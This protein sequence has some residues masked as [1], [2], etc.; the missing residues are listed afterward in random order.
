M[1]TN[2]CLINL[3]R[4]AHFPNESP[5]LQFRT[6]PRSPSPTSDT[7]DTGGKESFTQWVHGEFI[8][9]SE[10]I[11]PPNIHWVQGEYF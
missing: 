11:F 9:G 1:D 4:S 2:P 8:V 6:L 3:F 10:T 5:P 7:S